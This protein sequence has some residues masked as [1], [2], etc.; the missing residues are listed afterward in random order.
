M[1]KE[2]ITNN[3]NLF[4]LNIPDKIKTYYGFWI[5]LIKAEGMMWESYI[6]M[7]DAF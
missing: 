3:S 5:L 4:H 1:K 6:V 2:K 7:I